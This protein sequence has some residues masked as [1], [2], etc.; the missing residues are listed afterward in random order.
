[1]TFSKRNNFASTPPITI[2]TDA[3]D[4]LRYAVIQTAYDCGPNYSQIRS[5]VCRVLLT[6][7]DQSNWSEVP[8]IRDEVL[9]EINHCDWYKVY[10]V[11]EALLGQIE[12]T[13]GYDAAVEFANAMNSFFIEAGIG[14]Q[15]VPNEGIVYRGDEPFQVTTADAAK[16]LQD[17]GRNNASS[18]IE[19][20]IRDISRRP[21]PDITG[22][23][24][25]SMAAVECVAQDILGSSNTLGKIA[26]HLNLPKPLDEAVSKLYGF[27]SQHGRHVNEQ[28]RPTPE[29]AELLVQVSCAVCAYLVKKQQP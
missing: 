29:D 20:A 23:I 5:V 10:D 3:P 2:R 14:W 9:Y 18:E 19:E 1:M 7:P 15:F 4:G 11:A 24:S 26:G 12:N 6:A 17:S 13:H 16:S 8:N 27:A 25:H 28:S 21:D 22:A